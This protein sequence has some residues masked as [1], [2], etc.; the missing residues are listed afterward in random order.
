MLLVEDELAL[1]VLVARM[2]ESFGYKVI[3]A[4]NGGEALLAMEAERLKL[5]CSLLMWLCRE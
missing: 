4:Q 3:S 5:D 1:R 2:L